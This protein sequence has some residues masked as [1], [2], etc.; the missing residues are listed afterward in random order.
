MMNFVTYNYKNA[1]KIWRSGNKKLPFCGMPYTWAWTKRPLS[2]NARLQLTNS[3]NTHFL[4]HLLC[5]TQ[6]QS[7][8][9]QIPKLQS[10]RLSLKTHVNF[11]VWNSH[12][13]YS[14]TKSHTQIQSF[15]LSMKTTETHLSFHQFDTNH[16]F[17]DG[18]VLRAWRKG[19]LEW[20]ESHMNPCRRKGG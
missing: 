15:N 16:S 2:W 17:S 6:S 13:N 7:S 8:A 19:V 1:G 10:F 9:I 5:K 18:L 3:D 4:K 20:G 12:Q 14:N 11:G